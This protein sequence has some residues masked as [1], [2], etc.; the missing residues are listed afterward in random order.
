MIV[1]MMTHDLEVSILAAPL[2]QMDRGALSQAW[3]TAL[4]LGPNARAGSSRAVAAPPPVSCESYSFF[5][6]CATPR[7]AKPSSPSATHL[8][9]RRLATG[10]DEMC[11]SAR[12]ARRATLAERIE[13][14]FAGAPQP[15]KRATF[16]LG[17]GNARV[18]IVLQT[19]GE[20]PTLLALCRPELRTL[21]G[22]ALA[23]ARLA[24]ARRGIG[25]DLCALGDV[26]NGGSQSCS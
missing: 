5:E 12:P 20:R 16:S 1:G 15:A 14:A 10:L 9:A 17:R 26:R 21:V 6:K 19:I 23:Q 8:P 13:R 7:A 2:A 3:Y 4:R 18:H 24:L 22:R 25:V 11:R